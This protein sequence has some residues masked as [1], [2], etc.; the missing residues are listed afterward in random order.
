MTD[1]FFRLKSFTS[2]KTSFFAGL[3]IGVIFPLTFLMFTRP[4][5]HSEYVYNGTEFK[6]AIS[7][8]ISFQLKEN[9][10]RAAYPYYDYFYNVSLSAIITPQTHVFIQL[11]VDQRQNK[12][13][14]TQ[15]SKEEF[16]Y[17]YHLFHEKTFKI[18]E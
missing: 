18:Q 12:T 16:D 9:P 13:I 14:I 8:Y 2:G 11:N 7:S 6:D 10:D 1:K 4:V 17:Y 15:I 5:Q 3:I